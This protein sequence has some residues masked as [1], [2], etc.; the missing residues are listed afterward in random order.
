MAKQVDPFAK[1]VK[2]VEALKAKFAKIKDEIADLSVLV[3]EE[4]KKASI[5]AQSETF[6]PKKVSPKKPTKPSSGTVIKSQGKPK[7]GKK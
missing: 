2:K 3:A 4:S 1:I 7:A 5:S 6:P